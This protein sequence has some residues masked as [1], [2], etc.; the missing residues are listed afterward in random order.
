METTPGQCWKK[1]LFSVIQN[2]LPLVKARP[3]AVKVTCVRVTS[4]SHD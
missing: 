2:A 4:L 1:S 3:L